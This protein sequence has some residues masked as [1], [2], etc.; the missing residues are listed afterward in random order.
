MLITRLLPLTR[1]QVER[2]DNAKRLQVKLKKHQGNKGLTENTSS[3]KLLKSPE[4][5]QAN[6][7]QMKAKRLELEAHE[8]AAAAAS[9]KAQQKDK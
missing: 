3:T 2:F 9:K 1:R 8:K 4:E 7:D 6:L 5:R